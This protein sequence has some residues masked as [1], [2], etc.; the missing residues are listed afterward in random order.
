MQRRKYRMSLP[1][2][3]H[4]AGADG[5]VAESERAQTQAAAGRPFTKVLMMALQGFASTA[6]QVKRSLK[7]LEATGA[8]VT[9][10]MLFEAV[11]KVRGWS[12]ATTESFI[13]RGRDLYKEANL[14]PEEVICVRLYTGVDV[15]G[16]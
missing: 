8:P 13:Q 16:K 11:H 6:K 9:M 3:S 2:S 15:G 10:P 12:Q 7:E 14:R 4:I 1:L 5:N